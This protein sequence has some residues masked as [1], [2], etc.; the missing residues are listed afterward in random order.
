MEDAEVGRLG[1]S[2]TLPHNPFTT[3]IDKV[4][5]AL[6]DLLAQLRIRF[7][8]EETFRVEEIDLE[9]RDW[10]GKFLCFPRQEIGHIKPVGAGS[11]IENIIVQ[12]VTLEPDG[13]V[14]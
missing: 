14:R 10:S 3:P 8:P 1:G 12:F 13:Y 11:L 2:Y 5:I 9:L 4:F 6:S 7:L